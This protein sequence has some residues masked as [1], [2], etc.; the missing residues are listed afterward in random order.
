MDSIE[1][2]PLEVFSM[3]LEETD[4]HR[5]TLCSCNLVSKIW[6]TATTPYLFRSIK[7]GKQLGDPKFYYTILYYTI[8]YF[9]RRLSKNRKLH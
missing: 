9:P 2:F 4:N 6:N 3:I 8:L 1:V 5:P 7:V